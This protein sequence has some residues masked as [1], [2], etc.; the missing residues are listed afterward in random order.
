MKLKTQSTMKLDVL[1]PDIDPI[2]TRCKLELTVFIV[3]ICCLG[4]L[5]QICA[6]N[7][8]CTR[9]HADT[10]NRTHGL[11]VHVAP[12]VREEEAPFAE[13]TFDVHGCGWERSGQRARTREVKGNAAA[14][15]GC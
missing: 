12:D 3:D 7:I 1:H 6:V 4:S 10:K 8:T 9:P 13:D 14:Y 15:L 2:P 5:A 11:G